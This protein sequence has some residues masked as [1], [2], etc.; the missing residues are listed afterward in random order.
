[1]ILV[2]PAE[3]A[4][5]RPPHTTFVQHPWPESVGA[6]FLST[7]PAGNLAGI[8]RKTVE[9]LIASLRDGRLQREIPQ[10]Q[11]LKYPLLLLEGRPKWTSEGKLASVHTEFSKA[12]LYGV[13]LSLQLAFQIPVLWTDSQA[14][15]IFVIQAYFS[16]IAARD[17]DETG[18]TAGSSSLLRRPGPGSES[19]GGPASDRSWQIHFL[20]GF[21]GIGPKQAERI[22]DHFSGRLPVA[23]TCGRKGLVEIPGLGPKTADRI[24]RLVQPSPPESNEKE[25]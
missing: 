3:P 23:L 9:D 1:M 11:T 4:I 15:S 12:Q 24:L 19:N 25:S 13:I 10:L 22:L 17:T 18:I 2:S 21:P 5:F 16:W 20:Q 14:D 8:Q 7:T 6:D